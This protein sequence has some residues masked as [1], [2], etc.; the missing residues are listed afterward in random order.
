[1]NQKACHSQSGHLSSFILST[2]HLSL[3][4]PVLQEA[5]SYWAAA[6]LITSVTLSSV[7]LTLSPLWQESE[8]HLKMMKFKKDMI[9]NSGRK[10]N[11][12]RLAG[13]AVSE[14]SR[15]C[16]SLLIKVG[17]SQDGVNG[18]H[19]ARSTVL[20]ALLLCSPLLVSL[21]AR[22]P[23]PLLTF[24]FDLLRC[25]RSAT[26]CRETANRRCWWRSLPT[27]AAKTNRTSLM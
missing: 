20:T 1:M 5:V 8:Y 25:W 27:S 9:L 15:I 16:S 4:A 19:R 10:W 3:C 18:C 11:R 17:M 7:P 21:S 2:H 23:R 26:P 12:M 13:G 14:Q 22:S 24:S 6:G